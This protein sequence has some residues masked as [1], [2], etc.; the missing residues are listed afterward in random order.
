MRVDCVSLESQDVIYCVSLVFA[1]DTLGWI[2][3]I[4]HILSWDTM[5]RNIFFGNPVVDCLNK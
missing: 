1:S 5:V 2:S 4:P 3:E